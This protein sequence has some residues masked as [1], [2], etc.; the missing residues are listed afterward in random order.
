MEFK[1]LLSLFVRMLE[2][3]VPGLV[4]RAPSLQSMSGIMDPSRHSEIS[5]I[6]GCSP[7]YLEKAN[8][9]SSPTAR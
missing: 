5:A 3:N 4:T 1:I 8:A 2:N 9:E 6:S 7:K